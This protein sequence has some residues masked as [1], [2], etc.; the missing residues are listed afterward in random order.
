MIIHLDISHEISHNS[1]LV[2][3][4]LSDETSKLL[5]LQNI[6]LKNKNTEI[7]LLFELDHFRKQDI[8]LSIE[9]VNSDIIKFPVTIRCVIL[10]NFY[11]LPKITYKTISNF[12]KNYLQY[13]KN[14]GLELDL[15]ASNS[16]FLNFTGSLD[17]KFIW[18]FFQNIFQ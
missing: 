14:I 5:T 9:C 3:F 11:S 2:S 1:L 15:N 13:I 12:D 10:D 18:P 17:Y 6:D 16:T 7:N 4:K 8:F